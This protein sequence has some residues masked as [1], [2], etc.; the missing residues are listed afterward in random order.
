MGNNCSENEAFIKVFGKEH[1]GHVRG[2]GLG[3]TPSQ[4]FGCSSRSTTST[5]DADSRKIEQMQSEI[6]SLKVRVAEV[7]VLKKQ[8]AF[9]M[10]VV[11]EGNQVKLSLKVTC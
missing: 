3:V 4:I 10:Q 1:P 5:S 11:K 7:D 2:M 8:L 6:D 9:L